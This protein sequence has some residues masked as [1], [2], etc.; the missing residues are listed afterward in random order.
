MKGNAHPCYTSLSIDLYISDALRADHADL[1]SPLRSISSKSDFLVASSI[2]DRWEHNPFL[3]MSTILSFSS[4]LLNK[5]LIPVMS[6][7]YEP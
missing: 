7:N 6:R 1:W 3:I 5:F 4:W 2:G